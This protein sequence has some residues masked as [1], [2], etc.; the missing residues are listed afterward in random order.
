MNAL[1]FSVL[2]MKIFALS[3]SGIFEISAFTLDSSI[4]SASSSCLRPAKL[5]TRII[6]I[7]VHTCSSYIVG[8]KFSDCSA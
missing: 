3:I 7:C 5:A 1:F 8:R 6:I 4:S 2:Y